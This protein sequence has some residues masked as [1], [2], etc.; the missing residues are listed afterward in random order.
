MRKEKLQGRNINSIEGDED[1]PTG[2][3]HWYSGSRSWFEDSKANK[4]N[5]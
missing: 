5:Y 1:W 4:E 2:L 3:S